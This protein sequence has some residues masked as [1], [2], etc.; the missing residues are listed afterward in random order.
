MKLRAS[1][2]LCMFRSLC[3]AHYVGASVSSR[4]VSWVC[5]PTREACIIFS[6]T[7]FTLCSRAC[8]PAALLYIFVVG[9][10][11]PSPI[12]FSTLDGY[13]C[14]QW[15]LV[16]RRSRFR[17]RRSSPRRFCLPTRPSFSVWLL[18]APLSASWSSSSFVL[19]SPD[20]MHLYPW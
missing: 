8:S 20:T 13:H 17:P 3:H 4:H 14:P 9:N 1:R 18:L 5:S 12:S 2:R 19:P 16:T 15:S 7:C 11:S 6:T 10:M